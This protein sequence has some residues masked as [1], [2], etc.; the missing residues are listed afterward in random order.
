VTFG[1]EEA[2]A[3]AHKQQHTAQRAAETTNLCQHHDK[4]F[5]ISQQHPLKPPPQPTLSKHHT[6]T[7][8]PHQLLASLTQTGS[9][10]LAHTVTA[11]PKCHP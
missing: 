11:K 5:H 8:T 6:T 9:P 4:A 10:K 1:D 3:R 2:D 7:N